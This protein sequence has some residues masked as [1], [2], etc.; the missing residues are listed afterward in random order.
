MQMNSNKKTKKPKKGKSPKK[1]PLPQN[2]KGDSP[3]NNHSDKFRSNY[4]SI[5]WSDK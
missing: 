1:K 5:K 4:D 3:R 2:G